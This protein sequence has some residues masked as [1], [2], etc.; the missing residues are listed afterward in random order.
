MVKEEVNDIGDTSGFAASRGV[1]RAVEVLRWCRKSGCGWQ[2]VD[3][4]RE[5]LNAFL[6]RVILILSVRVRRAATMLAIVMVVD[7]HLADVRWW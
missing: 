6:P 4:R 3:C 2:R 5:E 1:L 7:Q